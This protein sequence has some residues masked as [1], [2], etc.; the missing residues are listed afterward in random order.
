M[1]IKIKGID[2]EVTEAINDYVTK[3]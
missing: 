3:K 2:I 1:N